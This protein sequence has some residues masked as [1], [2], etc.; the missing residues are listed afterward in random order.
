MLLAPSSIVNL[1]LL[2]LML[3][4]AFLSLLSFI[5]CFAKKSF[6][7]FNFFHKWLINLKKHISTNTMNK[8]E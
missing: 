7:N 3:L 5:L 1:M 8:L 4:N 2:N 6:I